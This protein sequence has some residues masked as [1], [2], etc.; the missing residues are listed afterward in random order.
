MIFMLFPIQK[1]I[2]K[3]IFCLPTDPQKYFDVSGNKTFIF[4]G[5]NTLFLQAKFFL[6]KKHFPLPLKKNCHRKTSVFTMGGNIL[7]A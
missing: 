6:I 2:S 3:K 4:F 5:P 7:A 1:I